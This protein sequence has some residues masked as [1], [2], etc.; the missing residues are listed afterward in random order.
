MG[1]TYFFFNEL[2]KAQATTHAE[3]SIF[4]DYALHKKQTEK[5]YGRFYVFCATVPYFKFLFNSR[6]ITA[7]LATGYMLYTV[8]DA[9]YD[10][11]V[12]THFFLHG[13]KYMRQ[14]LELP[15]TENFGSI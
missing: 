4:K 13:H 1:D 14:L 15:P 7:K 3:N 2:I 11:G 9:M 5:Y 12:Y 8:L 6:S 10:M